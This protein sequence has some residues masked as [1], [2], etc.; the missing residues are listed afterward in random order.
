MLLFSQHSKGIASTLLLRCAWENLPTERCELS[1]H[2]SWPPNNGFPA[3]FAQHLV[4]AAAAAAEL[5]PHLVINFVLEVAVLEAVADCEHAH[6]HV[7]D[8]LEGAGLDVPGVV[9]SHVGCHSLGGQHVLHRAEHRR[10]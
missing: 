7:E 9:C 8:W 6:H 2:R 1:H 4:V 3:F 5:C 10:L